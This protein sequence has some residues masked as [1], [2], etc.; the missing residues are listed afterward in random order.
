MRLTTLF[1]V[2]LTAAILALLFWFFRPQE[3]AP[4]AAPV[5]TLQSESAPRPI[6]PAPTVYIIALEDGHR[7]AGPALIS[8]TQGDNITIDFTSDTQ[9][10]LHLHGYDIKLQLMPGKTARLHFTA[11]HAGRFEYELHGHSAGHHALGAI[12]VLPR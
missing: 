2:L 10:E 7:T 12:E 4:S 3:A 6:N 8:A 9:A 1:F 11:T 5:N